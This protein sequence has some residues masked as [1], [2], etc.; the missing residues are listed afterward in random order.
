MSDHRITRVP[1]PP[2]TP[3]WD[4]APMPPRAI[5]AE[6]VKVTLARATDAVKTLLWRQG[7]K[8]TEG[9]AEQVA[10]WALAAA[11]VAERVGR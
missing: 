3:E 8:V 5:V 6:D 9:E 10:A 1:R 2:G 7:Y 4:L 11:H